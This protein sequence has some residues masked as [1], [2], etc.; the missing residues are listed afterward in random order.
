MNKQHFQAAMAYL[1]AANIFKKNTGGF[2]AAK[3]TE[4]LAA[5]VVNEWLAAEGDCRM[6]EAVTAHS[7][8]DCHLTEGGQPIAG[9]NQ[10]EIKSRNGGDAFPFSWRFLPSGTVHKTTEIKLNQGACA[11]DTHAMVIC[12]THDDGEIKKIYVAFGPLVMTE[13]A[14]A[15]RLDTLRAS[16]TPAGEKK[17]DQPQLYGATSGTVRKTSLEDLEKHFPF[18]TTRGSNWIAVL[19][20]QH[21]KWP[22]LMTTLT[23]AAG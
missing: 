22:R 18:H 10:V 20:P 3:A 19:S 2:N 23:G 6:L 21:P 8:A 11:F 17:A 15:L 4:L 7:G 9:S 13:L 1:N 14:E 12:A 16:F 5:A